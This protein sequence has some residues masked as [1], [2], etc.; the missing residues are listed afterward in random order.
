VIAPADE[1]YGPGLVRFL[2]HAHASSTQDTVIAAERIPGLGDAAPHS[3]VLDGLG[4][5]RL[6]HQQFRDVSPQFPD[7]VG[8]GVYHHALLGHQGARSRDLGTAVLH[9]LDD[10]EPAGAHLGHVREM[11][12]VRNADAVKEG[13]V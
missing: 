3:D 2:A 4:V 6:G 11:A 10:T 7:P 5:G 9:V 1:S 12:Q 8:I 13:G